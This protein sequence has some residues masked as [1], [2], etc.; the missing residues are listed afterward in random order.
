MTLEPG[1]VL[2]FETRSAVGRNAWYILRVAIVVFL[3]VWLLLMQRTYLHLMDLSGFAGGAQLFAVTSY[4]GMS[5]AVGFVIV[6]LLAPIPALNT[7]SR[8]RGKYM[9]PLLL[10]SRLS[11]RQIVWQSFAACMVPGVSLWLCTVPFSA[12]LIR[13]WGLDTKYFATVAAVTL[14]SMAACVALSVAF[15]LWT[16]GVLSATFAVY[17]VLVGW[18]YG[19]LWQVGPGVFAPWVATVNPLVLI[20]PGRTGR[21]TPEEAA[22]FVLAATLFAIAL[23]EIAAATFRRSVLAREGARFRRAPG[24][25]TVFRQA[26]SRRVAWFPGPTLDGN[27][28]FWREMRRVRSAFGLQ[29]FW[30]VYL[31]CS[32]AATVIGARHYWL[33]DVAETRLAGAAGYEVG[34]G[35]LALAVQAAL[36]WSEEKSVGREGLELLLS[37]P[38]S[39][40]TIIRGKWWS[41][42]Q[43]IVLVAIFPVISS[44]IWMSDAPGLRRSPLRDCIAG[45]FAASTNGCGGF[46]L[47]PVVDPDLQLPRSRSRWNGR[48]RLAVANQAADDV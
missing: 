28:V 30:G 34:I 8:R 35:V 15:S 5:V 6:F 31:L 45:Q 7:F 9:L 37:T 42:G 11:G 25:L 36:V 29:V 10:V 47:H 40:A 48:G 4:S 33:G 38:L 13:W 3:A 44:L 16:K 27:P 21:P 14:S 19:T 46:R 1:P 2:R 23:L 18:L 41:V 12:F 26:A 32:A 20:W 24:R 22:L 39:G 43:H 17:V